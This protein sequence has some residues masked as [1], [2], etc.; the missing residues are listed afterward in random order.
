MFTKS[1]ATRTPSYNGDKGV[2]KVDMRMRVLYVT[3][4]AVTVDCQGC[5]VE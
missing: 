3:N 4:R 5:H 2:H 1:V